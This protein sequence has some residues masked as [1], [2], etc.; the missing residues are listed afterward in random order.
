MRSLPIPAPILVEGLDQQSRIIGACL[1]NRSNA[2]IPTPMSSRSNIARGKER[3]RHKSAP[4]GTRL[5]LT[6]G[7]IWKDA[8]NAVSCSIADHQSP[9]WSSLGVTMMEGPKF[10]R[11]ISEIS[12][13]NWARLTEHD[14]ADVA[15]AYYYFSIQFRE[16]LEIA[17]RLHPDDAKLQ[18]LEQEEC[19]TDNLSP[20]PDVAKPAEKMNHDEFMRRLLQLSPMDDKRR[21]RLEEIGQSYL[22]ATREMDSVA[23]ALSIASYEDGGLERVFSS[24]LRAEHWN[25]PLLQA[26]KH[27]VTEHLRFDSDP[28]QG[29]GALSRHLTPDD[30]I[31][32]LWKAFRDLLVKAVPKLTSRAEVHELEPQLH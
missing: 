1:Q 22:T 26:F 25:S 17:R 19:N 2:I 9:S 15:R 32:P 11:V 23:R 28:E 29:H 14:L 16:S 30:R 4:L 10:E 6:F 8:L 21:S 27:F 12:G 24:F 7:F 20:W 18:Q 3:R 5:G 13:L 31:L